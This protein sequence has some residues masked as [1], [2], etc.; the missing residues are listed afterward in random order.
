MERNVFGDGHPDLAFI[1]L[2]AGD[3]QIMGPNMRSVRSLANE[4][5]RAEGF[6]IIRKYQDEISMLNG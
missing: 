3:H 2:N 1:S 6:E 5:E 4:R